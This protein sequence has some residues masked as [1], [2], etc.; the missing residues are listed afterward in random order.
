MRYLPMALAGCLLA[1]SPAFAQ[2]IDKVPS[3]LVSGHGEVKTDPD[4]AVIGYT[5][6]GEGATSDDALRA[7]VVQG[8]AIEGGI[9]ALDR[10]AIPRTND[11]STQPVRSDACKENSYG[12]KQLSTGACAVLGYVATQSIT[13][14]TSHF[15][16]AGTMVGLASRGGASNASI[17]SFQYNDRERARTAALAAAA[18]DAAAKARAVAAANRVT[19]GQVL[20][21]S[22]GSTGLE[23]QAFER[24]APAPPPPPPPPPPPVL[25]DITPVQLTTA[26]DVT[27]RYAIVR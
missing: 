6:R 8:K 2:D 20:S 12:A 14:E 11:V 27:V 10:N 3:I 25:V 23:A 13:V 26:A 22:S 19:L 24:D 16:D 21:I 1:S 4:Q 17:N 5:L 18:A 9:R 7:M 15:K